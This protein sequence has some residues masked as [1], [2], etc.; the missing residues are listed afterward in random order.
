MSEQEVGARR[1]SR[2]TLVIAEDRCKGCEL[3]IDACPPGV[4]VMSSE[5]NEMG[6]R[7]PELTPGCTGCTACQ[8]VCPDFVFSVYR[9]TSAGASGDRHG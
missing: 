7:Y 8:L 1:G 4:L 5:V 3:C 2:G 9:F 6:Y